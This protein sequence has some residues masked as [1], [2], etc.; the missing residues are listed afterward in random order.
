M[1]MNVTY[2]SRHSNVMDKETDAGE[3]PLM[4]VTQKGEF[5]HYK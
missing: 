2:L 4:Q 1:N 5:G 3:V